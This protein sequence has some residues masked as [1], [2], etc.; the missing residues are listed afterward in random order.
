MLAPAR[1]ANGAADF[2]R[3][4]RQPMD[5]SRA[6]PIKR[7]VITDLLEKHLYP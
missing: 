5:I 6:P 1:L 2:L 4:A 3:T 7:N